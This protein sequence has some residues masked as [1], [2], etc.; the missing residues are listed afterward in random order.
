MMSS[1]TNLG[2]QFL[3]GRLCHFHRYPIKCQANS[4]G[5]DKFS[6]MRQLS[7]P[8]FAL[9]EIVSQ[10]WGNMS[11]QQRSRLR[12]HLCLPPSR[13]VVLFSQKPASARWLLPFPF[14]YRHSSHRRF[15]RPTGE[16]QDSEKKSTCLMDGFHSAGILDRGGHRVQY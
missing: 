14:H 12:D 3:R 13:S 5:P 6:V 7:F 4:V 11:D 15:F 8:A 2:C 10:P 16:K 9:R 1:G